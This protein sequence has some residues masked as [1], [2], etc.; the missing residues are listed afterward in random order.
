M[1]TTYEVNEEKG[2]IKET[3]TEQSTRTYQKQNLIDT[4][5]RLQSILDRFK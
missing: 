3:S 4:I 2:E 1:E 5:A